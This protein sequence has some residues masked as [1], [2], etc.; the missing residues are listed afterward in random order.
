MFSLCFVVTATKFRAWLGQ[1]KAWCVASRFDQ[2][3]RD[4]S[5][6]VTHAA[7]SSFSQRRSHHQK[8]QQINPF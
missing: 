8:F 4:F 1:E 7:E 6:P 5:V 2:C 3:W